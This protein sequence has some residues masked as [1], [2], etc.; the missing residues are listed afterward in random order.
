MESLQLSEAAPDYDVACGGSFFQAKQPSFATL[1]RQNC[2]V[3]DRKRVSNLSIT[4]H[5]KAPDRAAGPWE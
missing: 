4:H 3:K 1:R 2:A 5:S